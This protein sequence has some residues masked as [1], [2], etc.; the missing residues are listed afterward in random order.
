MWEQRSC[1]IT[2]DRKVVSYKPHVFRMGQLTCSMVIFLHKAMS[3]LGFHPVPL[4]ACTLSLVLLPVPVSMLAFTLYTSLYQA[5]PIITL[6]LQRK[7]SAKLQ[8]QLRQ[9]PARS[10][11]KTAATTTS[12]TAAAYLPAA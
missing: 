3:V 5:L 9:T 1:A 11:D 2:T 8:P 7:L 4:L 12:T 6:M 10:E